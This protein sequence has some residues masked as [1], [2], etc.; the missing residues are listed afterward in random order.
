MILQVR[1]DLTLVLR[2][3]RLPQNSQGINFESISLG[4]L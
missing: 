1:E 4:N 3:A 2:F